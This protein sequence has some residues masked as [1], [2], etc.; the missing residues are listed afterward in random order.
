MIRW[1]WCVMLCSVIGFSSAWAEEIQLENGDKMDVKI[2]SED[3]DKLVVEH[4]QLG[5]M[6]IPKSD[7]KKPDPPNPGLFGTQFMEGWARRVG[8]GFSGASGNSMTPA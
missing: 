5:E 4:P 7:L 3:D 2:L 1:F 6:T 8:F